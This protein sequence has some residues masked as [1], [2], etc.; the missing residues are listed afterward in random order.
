MT[1]FV[2]IVCVLFISADLWRSLAAR[3]QQLDEMTT[4]SSNL[5]R[6]MAQHAD[7]TFKEADIIVAGIVERVQHDGTDPAAIERLV[8]LQS[9]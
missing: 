7:D 2:A 9:R 3:T 8:R 1:A 5:A 4:A 6:A